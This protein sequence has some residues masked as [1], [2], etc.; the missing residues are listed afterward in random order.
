MLL[1]VLSDL[2]SLQPYVIGFPLFHGL[3]VGCFVLSDLKSLQPYVIGFP[4]FHGL[5][6]GSCHVVRSEIPATLCYWVSSF[7]WPAG[8][9]LL[10]CQICNFYQEEGG[11]DGCLDFGLLK[12][13][14]LNL[15]IDES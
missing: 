10:C 6:V 7:S 5:L 9:L 13:P 2:K 8:R 1:F 15:R 11:R 14:F 3:L 12:K 4:L